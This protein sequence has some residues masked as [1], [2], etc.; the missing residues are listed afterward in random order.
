MFH[1]HQA[2][3]GP[4]LVT[5]PRK[6]TSTADAVG[7]RTDCCAV[8]MPMRAYKGAQERFDTAAFLSL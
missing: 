6:V 8:I 1:I 7:P 5:F 3:E 4:A 2:G